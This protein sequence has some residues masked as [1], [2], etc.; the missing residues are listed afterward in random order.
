MAV[1]VATAVAA[2]PVITHAHTTGPVRIALRSFAQAQRP[3]LAQDD[4]GSDDEAAVPTDQVNKYIAVYLAMQKNHSLTVDQAAPQQG[5]TVDQFRDI[6]DKIGRNPVIHERVLDALTRSK[7][8]DAG[9]KSKAAPS[10]SDS[11]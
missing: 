6:E 7:S 10:D 3:I 8:A 9:K 4:N 2:S 11:N 5:L 1:A